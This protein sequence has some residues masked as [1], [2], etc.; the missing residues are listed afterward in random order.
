MMCKKR[1]KSAAP[2]LS[3]LLDKFQRLSNCNCLLETRT[4]PSSVSSIRNSNELLYYYEQCKFFV[5]INF[6]G[7]ETFQ[8]C[9]T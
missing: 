2:F 8:K 7:F 3:N 5:K 4:F 6:N 1:K 9:P